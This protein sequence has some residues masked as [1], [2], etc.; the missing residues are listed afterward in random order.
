MYSADV[1]L[2]IKSHALCPP[3]RS[4]IYEGIPAS[5]RGEF[6]RCGLCWNTQL[7]MIR[8]PSEDYNK[9]DNV[10]C[11][12]GVDR[13]GRTGRKPLQ[14]LWRMV[15]PRFE[16]IVYSYYTT[17]GGPRQ[18][19]PSGEAKRRARCAVKRRAGIRDWMGGGMQGG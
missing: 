12:S 7:Q 4:S 3:S 14:D 8:N 10:F 5:R 18:L 19:G 9:I 2:K 1:D 11:P 6:G 13:S 16:V 15:E 17:T